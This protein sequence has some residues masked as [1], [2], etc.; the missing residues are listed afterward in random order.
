MQYACRNIFNTIKTSGDGSLEKYTSHFI[1]RIVCE[2]WVGDKTDLQHIDPQLVWLSQPFFPV[3]LLCSTG[4]L[5]AQPLCWEL[6]ITARSGT[7]TSSSELQLPDFLSH[8]GYIIV[9][10]P[11]NS[12]RRQLRYP[13]I[14]STGCTCYLLRC[15]SHLTVWPGRRSIYNTQSLVPLLGSVLSEVLHL[16]V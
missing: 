8:P 11:L 10:R 9:L 12:T 13:L 2:K 15:I 1:E 6:V 3:L 16:S 7:L 14:S 5:G 4:G